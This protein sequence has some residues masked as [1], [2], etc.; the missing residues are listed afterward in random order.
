MC[1]SVIV[2]TGQSNASKHGHVGKGIEADTAMWPRVLKPH[3]A[4]LMQ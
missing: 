4:A 1:V 3:K 2:Q